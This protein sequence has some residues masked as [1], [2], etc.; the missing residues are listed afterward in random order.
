M[1]GQAGQ[2]NKKQSNF[3]VL[4][5]PHNIAEKMAVGRTPHNLLPCTKLIELT[6]MGRLTYKCPR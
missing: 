3:V 6:S 5:A 4:V 1:S 2:S